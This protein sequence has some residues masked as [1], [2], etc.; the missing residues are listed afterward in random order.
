[1][2]LSRLTKSRDYHF[3]FGIGTWGIDILPNINKFFLFCFWS[4]YPVLYVAEERR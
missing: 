1:M 3:R 2:G 4:T